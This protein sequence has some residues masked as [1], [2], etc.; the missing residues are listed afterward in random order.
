MFPRRFLAAALVAGA[1]AFVPPAQ[2]LRGVKPSALA[3][4]A[5]LVDHGTFTISFAG[6][7]IGEEKFDIRSS[8]ENVNA[9]AE[10]RMHIEQAGQIVELQSSPKLVLNL[11]LEPQTYTCNQKGALAFHLEVDFRSSPAKS[12]LQIPGAQN[13]D[14]MFDLPKDIVILDDNV[15]HHYQLLV[16][17]YQATPGGTQTFKAYIPQ[18]ALPGEVNIIDA[19]AETVDV[20]GQKGTLQHLVVSTDLARIDL[21]VDKQQ[22]LQRMSIPATRLEAARKK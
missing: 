6:R 19:G 5:S 20:G 10:I 8:P 15:V 16:D 9:E 1:C 21:W 2:R 17:R 7:N 22:R 13:D 3:S 18:E 12:L 11:Q 14:R 4:S